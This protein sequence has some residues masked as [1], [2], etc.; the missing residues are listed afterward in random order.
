MMMMI[1]MIPIDTHNTQVVR[2]MTI[3]S[4]QVRWRH[5]NNPWKKLP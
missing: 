3:L 5:F 1:K 2:V 4:F